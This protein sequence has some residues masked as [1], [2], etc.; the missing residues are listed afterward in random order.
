MS[1][2]ERKA[3]EGICFKKFRL[4]RGKD[5]PAEEAPPLPPPVIIRV[6]ECENEPLN[7]GKDSY[8]DYLVQYKIEVEDTQRER[9]AHAREVIRELRA[10]KKEEGIVDDPYMG[11][12]I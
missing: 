10:K 2:Q 11:A 8:A 4:R 12:W 6:L 1:F 7:P 3:R 5:R 9:M